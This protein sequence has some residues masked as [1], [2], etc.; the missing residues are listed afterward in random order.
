M[1][2]REEISTHARIGNRYIQLI[3]S[4]MKTEG[5]AGGGFPAL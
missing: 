2:Q 4:G 1:P 3:V 5:G